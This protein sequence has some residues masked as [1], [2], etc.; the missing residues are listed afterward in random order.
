MQRS[1]A[2]HRGRCRLDQ[3]A[4]QALREELPIVRQLASDQRSQITA[5]ELEVMCL[6]KHVSKRAASMRTIVHY[7]ARLLRCAAEAAERTNAQPD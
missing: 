5:L 3:S 2:L 1:A 7:S 4:L 6:R